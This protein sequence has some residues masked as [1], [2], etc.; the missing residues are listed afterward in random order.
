MLF[1]LCK[2]DKNKPPRLK[3]KQ[4]S[5]G[6]SFTGLQYFQHSLVWMWVKCSWAKW[7]HFYWMMLRNKHKTEKCVLGS[8]AKSLREARWMTAVSLA[9]GATPTLSQDNVGASVGRIRPDSPRFHWTTR[10][11]KTSEGPTQ[12][13][14][15]VAAATSCWKK[16][17][18]NTV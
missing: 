3:R 6:A 18:K 7:L 15:L 2:L 9:A 10:R 14:T 11:S 12:V 16:N 4:K 5:E 1:L 17:N 8:R 13:G